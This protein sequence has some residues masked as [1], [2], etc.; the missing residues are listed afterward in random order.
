M[1][2]VLEKPAPKKATT[3]ARTPFYEAKSAASGWLGCPPIWSTPPDYPSRSRCQ[4]VVLDT[5]RQEA[6]RIVA[7]YRK[8]E[9]LSAAND[10][11]WRQSQL[12]N[13]SKGLT[14]EQA[15]QILRE[16]LKGESKDF[17]AA[18]AQLRELR[19]AAIDLA[20][21]ILSRLVKSF[22]AELQKRAIEN[23]QRLERCGVPLSNSLAW[24]QWNRIRSERT[25]TILI[26]QTPL[27]PEP[28]TED[29]ELWHDPATLIPHSWRELARNAL[30]NLDS[31][32][33]IGA[34]QWLATSEEHVPNVEW[35]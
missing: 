18:Q 8:A 27:P 13:S 10:L 14:G 3:K 15:Q 9:K 7:E 31:T 17:M 26:V 5:E 24:Q 11:N 2:A 12:H 4:S 32:N 29:Y 16:M 28:V 34:V 20:T 35:V 30:R 22:D 25:S 19:D 21:T 1:K 23:E 6:E 33:A